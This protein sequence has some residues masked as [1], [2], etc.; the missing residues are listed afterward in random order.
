MG[1]IIGNVVGV[2]R[3][4]VGV[5]RLRVFSLSCGWLC[6]VQVLSI[7]VIRK[8]FCSRVFGFYFWAKDRESICGAGKRE[9]EGAVAFDA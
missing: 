7:F 4:I 9:Y 3:E 1:R 5:Y 2:E 6:G 8:P